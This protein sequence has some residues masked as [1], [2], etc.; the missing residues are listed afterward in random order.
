MLITVR[1]GP[2]SEVERGPGQRQEQDQVERERRDARYNNFIILI[3][4]GHNITFGC[5]WLLAL[6]LIM[7]NLCY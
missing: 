7:M 2:E 4:L 5:H 1:I 6:I 3:G